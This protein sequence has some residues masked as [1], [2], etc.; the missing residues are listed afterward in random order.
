MNVKIVPTLICLFSNLTIFSMITTSINSTDFYEKDFT[1]TG[2]NYH[3]G[4]PPKGAFKILW[5][6]LKS[7]EKEGKKWQISPQKEI[8]KC[9]GK[10]QGILEY[11]DILNSLYLDLFYFSFY[12]IMY[13]ISIVLKN[14]CN[15]LN[16]KNRWNWDTKFLYFESACKMVSFIKGSQ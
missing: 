12:F 14:C 1:D 8:W 13:F 15:L 11:A 2:Y 9:T 5:R 10:N 6:F 16:H 3:Y 4:K 7:Y